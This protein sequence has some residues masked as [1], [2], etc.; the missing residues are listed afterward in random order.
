MLEVKTNLNDGIIRF[1]HLYN[2]IVDE[3][4]FDFM[5]KLHKI[6]IER[7]MK[8]HGKV[9]AHCMMILALSGQHSCNIR[10]RFL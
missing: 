10:T 2:K 7:T 8:S 1:A 9:W 5:Y 6:I 3:F 4:E